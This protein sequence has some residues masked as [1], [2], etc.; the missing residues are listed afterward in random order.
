M[1][2]IQLQPKPTQTCYLGAR[3]YFNRVRLCFPGVHRVHVANGEIEFRQQSRKYIFDFKTL[4]RLNWAVTFKGWGRVI[5]HACHQVSLNLVH[6]EMSRL[7]SFLQKLKEGELMYWED[8]G[9]VGVGGGR[10]EQTTK[11][12]RLK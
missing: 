5:Y 6:A 3:S 10:G 11:G 7:I 4:R 12:I 9:G 1:E 2:T 8:E